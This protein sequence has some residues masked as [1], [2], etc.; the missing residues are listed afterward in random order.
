MRESGTLAHPREQHPWMANVSRCRTHDSGT[1]GLTC[2]LG[3][4]PSTDGEPTPSRWRRGGL[5]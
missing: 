3:D 1:N 5:R 2:L 4:L